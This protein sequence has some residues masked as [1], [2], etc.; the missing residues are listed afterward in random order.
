MSEH[1]AQASAATRPSRPIYGR[2]SARSPATGGSAS[3]PGSPGSSSRWSSSSSK[4]VGHDGG[5]PRRPAVPA[6][7]R[8]ERRAR[9]GARRASLG[10]GAVQRPV[11]RVRGDLLHRS[12]R[13]VRGPGGHAWFPVPRRR[14]VVDGPGV[15]GEAGQPA[16]VDW[17]HLRRPDDRH[18]VLGGRPALRHEGIHTAGVR[19]HLGAD[20][21]NHRLV[22]AFEVRRVHKD[23]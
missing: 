4:G 6:R 13:H 8:T 2:R 7:R 10:P 21:G 11:P 1:T 5:H 9:N 20:A 19:R 16:V 14:R 12:C 15:S 18:R 3:S 22:R 17:P 23:I